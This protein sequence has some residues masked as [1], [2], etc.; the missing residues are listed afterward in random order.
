MISRLH[1]SE[2]LKNILRNTFSNVDKDDSNG[3]NLKE[4]LLF[5]LK[6]PLF[7]QELL[8]NENNNAPYNYEDT[9]TRR[10][11]IRQWFYCIVECP[12]YNF[13]SR[14]LFCIDV[15]L[16]LFSIG[17][18][19]CEGVAPSIKLTY[20]KQCTMWIVT[21]FFALEY[22]CGLMTCKYKI[23]FIFNI[24]HVFELTSFLA[25]IICYYYSQNWTY[26]PIG[27]VGFRVIRF[28]D[29][30]QV[31]KIERL[32]QDIDIY[33]NTLTLAYIASGAVIMLLICCI[34]I[35]ALLVYVFERG[36]YNDT[37]KRWERDPIEG[38]SPFADL[39]TCIYFTVVTMTT[40]GY[41]DISPKSFMGRLVA[42]IM[43]FVGL[44]NMPFLINIVGECFEDAFQKFILIRTNKMQEEHN[45]DL[46]ECVEHFVK[47]KECC[48]SLRNQ[49]RLRCLRL[50]DAANKEE[51]EK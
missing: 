51:H 20:I 42:M 35:F 48:W 26:D 36:S 43:V 24:V 15:V 34:F 3:I 41:G 33:V 9:L 46:M 47:G 10:Q 50:I 14:L 44:F 13:A 39:Y 27:F 38:E 1:L 5:F 30:R 11:R 25:W 23:N 32:H 17:I 31:F 28:V 22:I 8:T 49:K 7:K 19:C 37:E 12:G 6:F 4:F 2:P 18:L 29:I 45:K 40:L 21:V 16:T